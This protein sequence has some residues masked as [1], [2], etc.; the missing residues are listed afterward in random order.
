[1]NCAAAY[2]RRS[3][4][5]IDNLEAVT[6]EGYRSGALTVYRTCRLLGFETRYELAHPSRRTMFGNKYIASRIRNGIASRS[7]NQKPKAA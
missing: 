3:G 7:D 4:S 6:I 2:S 1:M 5:G